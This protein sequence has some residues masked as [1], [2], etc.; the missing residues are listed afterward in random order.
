[1]KGRAARIFSFSRPSPIRARADRLPLAVAEDRER[2]LRG[3][4]LVIGEAR[5]LRARRLE[6]DRLRRVVGGDEGGGEGRPLS[7]VP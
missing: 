2:E 6:V 3:E 7:P 1:M 4:Q 5:E